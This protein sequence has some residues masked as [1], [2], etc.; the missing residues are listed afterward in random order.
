MKK[1]YNS[2]E[3]QVRE[4]WKITDLKLAKEKLIEIV[5]NDLYRST[6]ESKYKFVENIKTKNSLNAV[7]QLASNINFQDNK[8]TASFKHL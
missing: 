6:R 1:G 4:I 2:I 5:N 3:E 7:Y 8:S